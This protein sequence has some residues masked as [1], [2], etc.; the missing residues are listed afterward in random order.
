MLLVF[1]GDLHGNQREDDRGF[2]TEG[3]PLP[4]AFR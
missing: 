2:D 4:D 3:C 1:Y